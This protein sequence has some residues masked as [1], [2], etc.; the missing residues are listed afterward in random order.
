MVAYYNQ[1][2]IKIEMRALIQ[3][4][5]KSCT[6]CE[7]LPDDFVDLIKHNFLA[8]YVS[9][10]P[11]LHSIEIGVEETGTPSSFLAYPKIKVYQYPLNDKKNKWLDKSFK[12]SK[13]DLAFYGRLLNKRNSIS[14]NADVIVM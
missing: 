6:N 9:Y 1:R 11:D 4:Y 5:L 2:E 10:N 3:D 8:K 13:T 12:T 14:K 7:V